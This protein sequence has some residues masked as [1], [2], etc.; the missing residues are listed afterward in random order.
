MRKDV[1]VFFDFLG[2]YNDSAV[3]SCIEG[4]YIFVDACCGIFRPCINMGNLLVK[5]TLLE[6]VEEWMQ[7][8]WG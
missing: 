6:E 5:F 1:V 4:F 2:F 7:N 8:V 3:A